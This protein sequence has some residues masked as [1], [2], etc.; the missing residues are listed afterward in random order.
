MQAKQ[1]PKAPATKKKSVGNS[2]QRSNVK[3]PTKKTKT[4]GNRKRSLSESSDDDT[5]SD[6]ELKGRHP[7]KR[8]KHGSHD[9]GEDVEEVEDISHNEDPEEVDE[10]GGAINEE[11][12]Y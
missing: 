9:A 2:R 10:N 12:S 1:Q 11:V 8:T 7:R 5:S 4:T 6:E 3:G